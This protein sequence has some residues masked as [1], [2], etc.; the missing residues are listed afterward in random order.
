MRHSVKRDGLSGIRG[1]TLIELSVVMAVTGILVASFLSA[2]N[3]YVQQQV[4]MKTELNVSMVTSALSNYLIQKG[5]YP[6]PARMDALRTDA[7][8]GMETECNPVMNCDDV[9]KTCVDNPNYPVYTYGTCPTSGGAAA[10]QAEVYGP[11]LPGLPE[12][13]QDGG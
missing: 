12:A 7:D 5:R 11:A 8:Y 4:R 2:Y 1:Y 6:C 13:G 3:L 9:A 10:G